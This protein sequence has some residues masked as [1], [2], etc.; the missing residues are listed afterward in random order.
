MSFLKDGFHLSLFYN[1]NSQAKQQMH[2][3]DYK[4]VLGLNMMVSNLVSWH[5]AEHELAVSINCTWHLWIMT[6]LCSVNWN[7]TSLNSCWSKLSRVAVSIVLGNTDLLHSYIQSQNKF[8]NVDKRQA[9]CSEIQAEI[10]LG[11]TS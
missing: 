3:Q 9:K 10:A 6:E 2:F 4:I 7:D 11:W 8:W 5:N 1:L